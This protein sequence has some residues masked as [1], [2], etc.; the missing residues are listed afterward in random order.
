MQ[1]GSVMNL[2]AYGQGHAVFSS[3]WALLAPERTCALKR[4]DGSPVEYDFSP[5]PE[6]DPISMTFHFGGRRM[7]RRT[8]CGMM[9]E[10]SEFGFDPIAPVFG[11]VLGASGLS[12]GAWLMFAE[13]FTFSDR[14]GRVSS[15]YVRRLLAW[16]AGGGY[17]PEGEGWLNELCEARWVRRRGSPACPDYKVD[18]LRFL[19]AFDALGLSCL[20]FGDPEGADSLPHGLGQVCGEADCPVCGV[21]GLAAAALADVPPVGRC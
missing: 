8:L 12:P 3:A 1:P 10:A 2:P 19:G 16:P 18:L 4:F 15:G 7:D 6:D 13:L 9:V 11:P 21:D 14:K 17:G 5:R 20:T